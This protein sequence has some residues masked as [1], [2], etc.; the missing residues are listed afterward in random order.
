MAVCNSDVRVHSETVSLHWAPGAG[1]QCME[2]ENKD[3]IKGAEEQG[4]KEIA[5]ENGTSDGGEK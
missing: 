2:E 5:S 3:D 1:I 4:E